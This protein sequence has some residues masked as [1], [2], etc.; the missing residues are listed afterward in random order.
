M[1]KWWEARGVTALWASSHP[2]PDA[3]SDSL[4]S[5]LLAVA[6]GLCVK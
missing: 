6:T 2:Q 4:R 1:A 3:P 5:R